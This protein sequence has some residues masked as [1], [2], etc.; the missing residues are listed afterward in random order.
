V[1][2]EVP[3][4]TCPCKTPSFG[5]KTETRKEIENHQ[6]KA[7]KLTLY[8][9]SYILVKDVSADYEATRQASAVFARRD[10]VVHY[11][12]DARG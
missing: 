7:S 5:R 10:I 8:R 4:V 1:G 6:R 11:E 3:R 9:V 2:A 12:R